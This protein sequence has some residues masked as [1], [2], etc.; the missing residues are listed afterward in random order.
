MHFFVAVP[1]ADPTEKLTHLFTPRVT[2]EHPEQD[3]DSARIFV[4]YMG[5]HLMSV[6]EL[7][8]ASVRKITDMAKDTPLEKFLL[9]YPLT[10]LLEDAPTP[11][12]GKPAWLP[13]ELQA[14]DLPPPPRLTDNWSLRAKP[15]KEDDFHQDFG[16]Y[17]PDDKRI[18]TLSLE[19]YERR[20]MPASPQPRA[21][22]FT[23]PSITVAATA[24]AIAGGL[25]SHFS[26]AMQGN[27]QKPVV[28][29]PAAPVNRLNFTAGF[30]LEPSGAHKK[31]PSETCHFPGGRTFKMSCFDVMRGL[32][33]KP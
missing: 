14:N 22:L 6:V 2:I 12:T 11:Y 3:S 18:A 20:L 5:N 21:R 8:A 19:A 28:Q 24:L 31:R 4:Q 17:S 9:S 27:V 7:T 15:E 13:L 29:E 10:K 26:Y 32:P 1:F 23:L 30:T 16:A 33:I 25:G